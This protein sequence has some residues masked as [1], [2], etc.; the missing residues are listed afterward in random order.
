MSPSNPLVFHCFW[1]RQT[2]KLARVGEQHKDRS[3]LKSLCWL[4]GLLLAR[5]LGDLVLSSCFHRKARL[6][7]SG[8]TRFSGLC[9]RRPDVWECFPPTCLPLGDPFH[10]RGLGRGKISRCA[11]PQVSLCHPQ[12]LLLS[13]LPHVSASHPQIP[14]NCLCP[15]S[16]LPGTL[17]QVGGLQILPQAAVLS[18]RGPCHP[19]QSHRV[20]RAPL[21]SPQHHPATNYSATG[22]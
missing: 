19:S 7:G 6:W 14:R 11:C 16:N 15:C 13:D 9:S 21:Q 2:C 5:V 22:G 17:S 18:R 8:A 3:A 20:A 4:G 12:H 10:T 1:I